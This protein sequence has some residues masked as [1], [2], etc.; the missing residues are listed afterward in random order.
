M[1][2]KLKYKKTKDIWEVT[3]PK[4][5][6]QNMNYYQMLDKGTSEAKR[7]RGSLEVYNKD[8]SL[9]ETREFST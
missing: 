2:L 9:K 8:G 4:I 1:K 3:G 6:H 7:L 5:R